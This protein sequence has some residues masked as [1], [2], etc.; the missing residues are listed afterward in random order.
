MGRKVLGEGSELGKRMGKLM[1]E[2]EPVI[3]KCLVI[4]KGQEGEVRT[5]RRG[6]SMFEEM[7]KIE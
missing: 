5:Q 1:K 6:V 2:V 4:V 3:G 7:A